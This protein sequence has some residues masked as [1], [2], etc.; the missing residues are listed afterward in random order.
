MFSVGGGVLANTA[1]DSSMFA[2]GSSVSVAAN[3]NQFPPQA[4]ETCN[5]VHIGAKVI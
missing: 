1:A 3:W 4:T 2:E 5:W